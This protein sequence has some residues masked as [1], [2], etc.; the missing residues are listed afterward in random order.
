M[1]AFFLH[2]PLPLHH[3]SIE[4]VTITLTVLRI[5]MKETVKNE[6]DVKVKV[7]MKMKVIVKVKVKVKMKM[8][9]KIEN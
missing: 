8:K 5:F 1:P 9:L 4:D 2:A 3:P 6:M 7:K